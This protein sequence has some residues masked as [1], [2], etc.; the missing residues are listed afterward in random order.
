M[1]PK[2]ADGGKTADVN[3]VTFFHMFFCFVVISALYFNCQWL[4]TQEKHFV[5]NILRYFMPFIREGD[6]KGEDRFI[7]LQAGNDERCNC[8][9]NSAFCKCKR[10]MRQSNNLG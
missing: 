3:V 6:A 8:F 5:R 7:D 9:K 1:R 10:K 4:K 2:T